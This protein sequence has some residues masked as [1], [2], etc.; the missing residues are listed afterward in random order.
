MFLINFELKILNFLLAF[1]I[2]KVAK[3]ADFF[4]MIFL[5]RTDPA[6]V[7]V[8]Q[9]MA[10][11]FWIFLLLFCSHYISF[12]MSFI[13]LL[14]I[15]FLFERNKGGDDQAPFSHFINVKKASK[16]S[17]SLR[18]INNFLMAIAV[19]KVIFF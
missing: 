12:S 10:L 3:L 8:L 15:K 11:H 4:K 7:R 9:V 14:I 19:T 2:A 13:E 1:S 16:P 5:S 18:E 6:S 17:Y